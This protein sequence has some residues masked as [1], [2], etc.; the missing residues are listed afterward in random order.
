MSER[1][2]V[3]TGVGLTSP[4]GK[5]T[6]ENWSSVKA[7]KTGIIHDPKDGLPD[8]L[9]YIGRVPEY[10]LPEDIAP[11]QIGQMKFLNRSAIFGFC[12]AGEAVSDARE[13]IQCT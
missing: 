6:G 4:I 12:A 11:K 9:Q 1:E 8:Y 10:L 3:I 5:N 2:V 13:T 7:M